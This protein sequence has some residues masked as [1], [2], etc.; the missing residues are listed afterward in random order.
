[1]QIEEI[2]LGLTI[3]HNLILGLGS[4]LVGFVFFG[5]AYFL[6]CKICHELSIGWARVEILIT[7]H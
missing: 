7:E 1:M 6:F 2:S 5:L 3:G 4:V